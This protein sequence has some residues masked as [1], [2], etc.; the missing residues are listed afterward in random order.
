MNVA[1]PVLTTQLE[2]LERIHQGKVRDVY[3]VDEGR[4][5]FVATDRISAFDRVLGSGIPAKGAVLTQTSNFWFATLAEVAPNHLLTTLAAE[6]PPVAA[7]AARELAGRAVLVEELP[8]VPIECIVR[9]YLAGSVQKEYDAT[10]EIYGVPLPPGIPLGGKLPEPIFTP[11]TKA[12]EGHDMPL[13]PT[14]LE[15]EIGA[16]LAGRLKEIS[17]RLF[18]AASE[19]CTTRGL[20]L[21]DTK[22]EFGQRA[23]G[24]LVLADEALTPDSSRFFKA[25]EHQPGRPPTPWDKQLVRDYLKTLPREAIEAEHAPVL[26]GEIVAETAR[27]YREVYALLSGRPLD[28]AVAEAI[29]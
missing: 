26:P 20:I 11:T 18:S 2:G 10:G 9:G 3:R 6:M 4:L 24:T 29:A 7:K 12:A 16:E 21:C 14:E 13:T 23:D 8:I 27:R 28:E 22:F 19:H 1:A 17:L 25:E 15:A 5:L